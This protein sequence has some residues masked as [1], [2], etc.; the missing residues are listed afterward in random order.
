ME[1][2]LLKVNNVHKLHSLHKL[3]MDR[4]VLSIH[5]AVASIVDKEVIR[6]ANKLLRTK[7]KI[8]KTT[9]QVDEYNY[10][11]MNTCDQC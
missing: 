8:H 7:Y 11:V 9:I 6:E 3:T 5:L 4:M 1:E 10:E 2:D